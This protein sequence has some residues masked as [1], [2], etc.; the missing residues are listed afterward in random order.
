MDSEINL[1]DVLHS[2][3]ET[4]RSFHQAL[5]FLGPSREHLMAVHQ[6][7]AATMM[8][9]LRLHLAVQASPNI[10]Y[11]A[12]IP[13]N[14]PERWDDPVV[15]RPT[16]AEISSATVEVTDEAA[17][18]TNCAICQDSLSPL[19]IRLIQCGHTFHNQCIAEWFTRS[20]HCPN[21]RHD[22]REVGHAVPTSADQVH[23]PPQVR[24]RLDAWL[25]GANPTNRTEDTEESD[26]HHA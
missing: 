17:T 11:T 3:L 13:I 6:R 20:V 9:I 25:V 21:C 5:R 23:T 26:E 4:D 12:T 15:V 19:H 22:V 24:N 2:I 10:T 1:L 7:N 8:S 16:S 14:L 18:S